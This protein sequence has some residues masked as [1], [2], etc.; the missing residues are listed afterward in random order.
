[1][2]DEQRNALEKSLAYACE[3]WANRIERGTGF[4]SI[5]GFNA[6]PFHPLAIHV[7][8]K[9]ARELLREKGIEP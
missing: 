6:S 8:G 9:L 2:T 3:A 5:N 1:M 4:I 7:T